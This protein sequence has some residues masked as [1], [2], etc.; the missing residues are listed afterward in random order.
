MT[1][2]INPMQIGIQPEEMFAEVLIRLNKKKGVGYS[3]KLDKLQEAVLEAKW[4]YPAV[5]RG[6]TLHGNEDYSFSPEATECFYE[7][8]QEGFLASIPDVG[9]ILTGNMR[10]LESIFEK[11]PEI[12]EAAKYICD[13]L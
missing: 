6:F 7:F 3:L 4:K 12:G 9:T 1:D 5:M 11:K 13:R 8:I 2:D 10:R